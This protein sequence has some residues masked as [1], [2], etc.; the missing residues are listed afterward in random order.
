MADFDATKS[1]AIRCRLDEILSANADI[2]KTLGNH[3]LLRVL[4]AKQT[5]RLA[6]VFRGDS[7]TEKQITFTY[8]CDTGST[9]LKTFDFSELPCDLEGGSAPITSGICHTDN[10]ACYVDKTVS[11][12]LCDSD[13]TFEELSGLALKSAIETLRGKL[14][15][16]VG[17]TL[18]SQLSPNTN[19]NT[20]GTIVG[21]STEY[22]SAEWTDCIF[23]S[24]MLDWNYTCQGSTT[25]IIING[26][27]LWKDVY[28]A[29]FSASCCDS[30]MNTFNGHDMTWDLKLDTLT[31]A[32]STLL[33]DPSKIAIYTRGVFTTEPQLIDSSKGL[34]AW[35]IEDDSI[36]LNINGSQESVK[37][38]ILC[39]K[40]CTG[41]NAN[42]V[43]TFDHKYR[44]FIKGG[45]LVAP[46]ICSTGCT[47]VMKFDNI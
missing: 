36:S 9:C 32:K 26:S 20:T 46:A 41:M 40:T 39:Q 31:G 27:N 14:C 16:T 19:A 18:L 24:L 15:E 47:G 4:G 6:D 1:L 25:P 35:T 43:P 45:I 13:Q 2:N 23:G 8:D 22:P 11:D 7:C 10:I 29:Q 17:T 28:K 34:Y 38:N 42:G 21:D 44:V 3:N 5:P 33:V 12:A 30:P 37:Y